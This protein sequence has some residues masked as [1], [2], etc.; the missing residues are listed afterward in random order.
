MCGGGGKHVLPPWQ[1][2]RPSL[3][4]E[5]DGRKRTPDKPPPRVWFKHWFPWRLA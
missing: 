4:G 2:K 5:D 3:P 1:P